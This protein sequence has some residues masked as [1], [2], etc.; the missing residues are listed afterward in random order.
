MTRLQRWM[1]E[2]MVIRR[3]RT[4][5][6]GGQAILE[7]ALVLPVLIL[8]IMACIE[9]GWYFTSRYELGTYSREIGYNIKEPF[10]LYWKHETAPRDWVDS[11]KNRK[12]SWLTADE[13]RDWSFDEYDGWYAFS[14]PAADDIIGHNYY[15]AAMDSKDFFIS[16]LKHTGIVLDEDKVDYT[17]NGGWYIKAEALN[18][19]MGGGSSWKQKRKQERSEFYYMDVTVDVFYE[20]EPITFIGKLLLAPNGS[21]TVSL[22]ESSRYTYNLP[23]S[24]LSN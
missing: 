16:R 4:C 22:E 18:M 17:I 23:P 11:S 21:D 8:I 7:F 2:T 5:R 6:E 20:Y 19:P 10:N 24:W 9:Y 12:P 13:K 14:A 15:I 3:R 1:E